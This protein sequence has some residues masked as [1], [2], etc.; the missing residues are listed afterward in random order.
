MAKLVPATCP[1]CGANVPIDPDREVVTC[2]FCGASSFIQTQK[3]PVT[4]QV[5]AQHMPVIHVTHPQKGC[6]PA[7]VV[8][9]VLATV[10]LG[11]ATTVAQCFVVGA[12]EMLARPNDFQTPVSPSPSPTP[13]ADPTTAVT[14]AQPSGPLVEED[15]FAD[16]TKLKARYEK[17]LGKPIMAKSL[18]IYQYYATLEAQNPKNPDHVDSY[19]LWANKV[20]RPEPVR[21]GSDKKQ[22]VQLLFS[23][24]GVDF[25]LV[26][27]LTKQALS[28]LKIEEGKITHV[29]LERDSFNAKRDPIWRVYVNGSR[30][31]GFIEFSITGE[32]R[33][34]AR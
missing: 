7:A 13:T 8:I 10:G 34:V 9:A 16:A 30:D 28:E 19:K 5:H 24:D 3:R 25:K 32:K 4:Q 18:V 14:E 21:L 26:S 6:A 17:T 2:Q 33:R 20:E 11:I 27:K 23:L 12:T 29:Y 1:K 22:L 31:S 15:Y